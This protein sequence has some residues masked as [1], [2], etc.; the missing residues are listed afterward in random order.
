MSAGQVRAM[1]DKLL[2]NVSKSVQVEGLIADLIFPKIP[3]KQKSG[4]LGGY[5]NNHLRIVNPLMGGK[6]K[7]PRV[8]AIVRTTETY[9]IEN[10]G[11]ESEVSPDDYDNVEQPFDAEADEVMG[12]ETMLKIHKERSVASVLTDTGVMTQNTTL[13]GAA[14]WNNY[15]TSNPLSDIKTAFGTTRDGSGKAPNSAAMDWA[16]YNQLKY[17]PGILEALGFSANR[18]GL[19]SREDIAKALDVKNLYVAEGVYNS[20]KL[21]Q[22]D[23]LAPLWGKDV[24][25]FYKPDSVAK[26]QTSLGYEMF[27]PGRDYAV[28]KFAVNNP[29]GSTGIVVTNSYDQLLSNIKAGYLI[30]NAIA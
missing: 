29:P 14:Q 1:V 2:T 16:V 20:A 19:L 7:A 25:F 30:K 18:A 21:G 6:G 9:L 17:H 26:H 23:V 12:L 22:A 28:S 5:G 8:D 11:L 13:V 4:L 15:S 27:I 10:Y 3:V 24:V